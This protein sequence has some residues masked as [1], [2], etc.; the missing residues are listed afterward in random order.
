MATKEE[1]AVIASLALIRA[2]FPKGHGG[3][4]REHLQEDYQNWVEIAVEDAMVVI[5][6][7]SKMGLLSFD[8]GA[9]VPSTTK[10]ERTT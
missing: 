10:D 3:E 8:N 5:N 4:S 6:V 1:V 7:L 2:W 9:M